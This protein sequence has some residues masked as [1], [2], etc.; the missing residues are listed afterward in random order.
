MKDSS[1][2]SK[3]NALPFSKRMNCSSPGP[4]S[5]Q[6]R[7]SSLSTCGPLEAECVTADF[8]IFSIHLQRESEKLRAHF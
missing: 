8:S 4:S 3:D 5:K 1:Q 6:I 7:H 2:L